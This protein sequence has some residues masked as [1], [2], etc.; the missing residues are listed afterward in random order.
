VFGSR[1][2]KKRKLAVNNSSAEA[3]RPNL[4]TSASLARTRCFVVTTESTVTIHSSFVSGCT[5]IFTGATAV[6]LSS[7]GKCERL[8]RNDKFC[9]V[10]E[11]PNAL[12]CPPAHF[13]LPGAVRTWVEI[14]ENTGLQTSVNIC[15]FGGHSMLKI[16]AF[17]GFENA[18]FCSG[19]ARRG[20]CRGSSSGGISIA[21][22][23]GKRG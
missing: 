16:R 21:K 5:E 1:S 6:H 11:K 20:L 12:K 8:K 4:F 3:P 10:A 9:R 18:D 23:I 14:G 7:R 17:L 19:P 2:S 15:D 13:D 22:D